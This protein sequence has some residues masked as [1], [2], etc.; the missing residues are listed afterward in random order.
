MP[1]F[2]LRR[3]HKQ[4]NAASRIKAVVPPL[5]IACI[6]MATTALAEVAPQD[7]IS[8]W[9]FDEGS[10]TTA[11]DSVGA[12]D[13]TIT[14]ATY[15]TGQ[16]GGALQ[17]SG[18]QN[19]KV[20]NDA[21]LNPSNI[22]IEAW[23]FPDNFGYYRAVVT[24]PYYSTY[25]GNPYYS[26]QFTPL[27]N[28]T[29]RPT[30]TVTVGGVRNHTAASTDLTPIGAW[31]HFV[32]TYDG[33]EARIY[34]DG[35]LAVVNAVTGS[36]DTSAPPLYIGGVNHPG[37]NNQFFGKIDEVALYN[38]ALTAEEVQQ[39]YQKGLQGLGCGITADSDGDGVPD[40]DDVCDG[41]DDNIDT[42]GDGVPD[43]CDICPLD[44]NND[45]DGDGV[46]DSDDQCLGDDASGD[47]DGDGLCDDGD[48][49]FGASNSDLD[50]D[51]VCDEGDLCF[52]DDA[53]GNSDGD[54][55]CNDLDACQG[56]DA[57]GDS[58]GD[59]FCDDIDVCPVDV[60]N[61]A[62]MDGFCESVDNCPQ[63]ANSSQ[64]DNDGDDLGDICDPDDDN[65]MVLDG[66]DNCP[67]DANAEQSDFD[68]DGDGDVC[69]RDD[70]GDG[71]LD[72]T[73]ACPGTGPG[74]VV[75]LEGADQ[76]CSIAD[77]CPCDNNWKN[78]GAYVRCVA[79]TSGAFV[80]VGLITEAEKGVIVSEAGQSDCGHKE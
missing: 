52:G 69:D 42:D 57:S 73:D 22:T 49:C 21:S 50:G 27:S 10:G 64:S 14:G 55:V 70:D 76:G 72:A 79:H 26:Y 77:L 51:G 36:I 17:F 29:R 35:A 15:T 13:G 30:F 66:D 1:F 43:F 24:K 18:Y 11:Y 6:V 56:D 45:T 3:T 7:V 2:R 9:K 23:V 78:H 12:N 39:A 58:D 75:A 19:V 41:G 4:P 32:S 59:L 40:E 16:A 31:S 48:P 80:D 63:T 60:E 65:D 34:L 8:C 38:R 37:S 68:G 71:V 25:W 67:L 74:D 46:C 61:D 62:D 53:T 33:Q 54:G 28:N 47:T 44:D 20:P 5:A